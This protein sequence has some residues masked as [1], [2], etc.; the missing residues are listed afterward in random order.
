M[1]LNP[2]F[3]YSPH[4][5]VDHIKALRREREMMKSQHILI[6]K[7]KERKLSLSIHQQDEK[8]LLKEMNCG[9]EYQLLQ[10]MRAKSYLENRIEAVVKIQRSYK[11]LLMR[12]MFKYIVSVLTKPQIWFF[13]RET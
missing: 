6:R 11:T 8:S 2:R 10:K 9:F 4:S 3:N 12:R 1:I 13:F 7:Q 5:N